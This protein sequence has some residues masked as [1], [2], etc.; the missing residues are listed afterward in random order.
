M[1]I[2]KMAL[3]ALTAATTATIT[4][5]VPQVTGV[6]MTQASGGRTVTISYTLADAPAVVTLEV[7]T[8]ANTS[9]AADDPGWT[10]I[11]GAAVCNA[12]GDVWKKVQAGNRTITWRPDLSWPDHIVPNGGARAKVTAWALDNTPDYMA[13]DVSAAAQPNTQ[14][15][16][17]S[18]DFVPGGVSSAEYKTSVIL[19]RKIMA[20]D[21]TWTMGSTTLETLRKSNEDRKSVV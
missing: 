13:V 9:A 8:N 20:K 4:A 14:T 17:P 3:G 12:K 10:S 7:Q 15:Y 2:R 5:A 21:V 11:G 6:T 16:Y 19:M 1:N 18:A